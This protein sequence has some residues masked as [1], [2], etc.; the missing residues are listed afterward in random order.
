MLSSSQLLLLERQCLN[1][2]YYL[3]KGEISQYLKRITVGGARREYKVHAGPSTT[4]NHSKNSCACRS[5]DSRV[6]LIISQQMRSW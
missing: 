1:N 4:M 3:E 2:L 6:A 5:T